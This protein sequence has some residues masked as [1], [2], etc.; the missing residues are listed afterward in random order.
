MNR[1]VRLKSLS[2][3]ERL[4]SGDTIATYAYRD[5]VQEDSSGKDRRKRKNGMRGGINVRN[6]SGRQVI[7]K[8]RRIIEKNEQK[9]TYF[10]NRLKQ[11]EFIDQPNQRLIGTAAGQADSYVDQLAILQTQLRELEKLYGGSV[12][13]RTTEEQD[14]RRIWGWTTEPAIRNRLPTEFMPFQ[15]YVANWHHWLADEDTHPFS[16]DLPTGEL[17]GFMLIKRTGDA[18]KVAKLEFIVIR[19]D[20][21]YQGYGTEAIQQAIDLIF[22]HLGADTFEVQVGVDNYAAFLCFE[23]CG[24][25][26][27]D[28]GRYGSLECY[29]MEIC[30][31]VWEGVRSAESISEHGDRE[32]LSVRTDAIGEGASP[33]L[34]AKLLAPLKELVSNR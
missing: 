28:Q 9:L 11:S 23:K 6:D 14:L 7:D 4:A 2:K 17:I 13:L 30:R 34:T 21:R 16:I 18:E 33:Y 31:E 29:R 10:Q 15:A 27:I 3:M 25:E 5:L 26:F 22:E 32:A 1:A 8:L 24:L 20:C 12:K 19:S